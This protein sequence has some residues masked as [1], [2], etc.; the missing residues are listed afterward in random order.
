M[1]TMTIKWNQKAWYDERKNGRIVGKKCYKWEG[2]R[3]DGRSF[4][5]LFIKREGFIAMT[6]NGTRI[7]V[8]KSQSEAEMLCVNAPGASTVGVKQV[9]A[10]VKVASA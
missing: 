7:G 3:S 6:F 8:G 1:T 5:I 4:R 2:Q 10:P 9:C